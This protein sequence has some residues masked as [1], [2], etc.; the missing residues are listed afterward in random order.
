MDDISRQ[1]GL[2]Q[3]NLYSIGH[4]NH[5]LET[6]LGL[7]ELHHIQV[8]VDVRSKPYSRYS[9]HFNSQEL[10]TSVKAQGLKYVF[11]GQ[12]LGGRP[13]ERDFYDAE[14]RVFYNKVA[15]SG[16]FQDGLARLENG[17]EKYRV[18]MMCSEEDPTRCHRHMLISR[19]L[20][21]HG[22]VVQ[23]VRGDG[24]LQ[25]EVELRQ[26]KAEDEPEQLSLFPNDEELKAWKSILSVLPKKP[27][28]NSSES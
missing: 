21:E 11:M 14:G 10:K 19:V 3:H 28:P 8:L 23:H 13:D 1:L 2:K 22:I 16:L 9:P 5:S 25:S 20:L 4:S 24:T 26:T 12:E 27:P 17:L 6:F 15:A 18:A 7:L